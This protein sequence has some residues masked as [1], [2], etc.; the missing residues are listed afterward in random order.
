MRSFVIGLHEKFGL[1]LTEKL[2]REEDEETLKQL[3]AEM[4]AWQYIHN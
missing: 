1:P 2:Q 3:R 4:Q